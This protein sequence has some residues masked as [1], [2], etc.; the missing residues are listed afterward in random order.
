VP[1]SI[2][3]DQDELGNGPDGAVLLQAVQEQVCSL[4]KCMLQGFS[5]LAQALRAMPWRT[6]TCVPA[7]NEMIS[8]EAD[9]G[10]IETFKDLLVEEYRLRGQCP[11]SHLDD[12]LRMLRTAY[13][14][15]YGLFGRGCDGASAG[16][17][18]HG[19]ALGTGE[20]VDFLRAE[21][22]R[23]ADAFDAGL[24]DFRRF[25]ESPTDCAVQRST[26]VALI[27]VLARAMG[28]STDEAWRENLTTAHSFL[29]E[30]AVFDHPTMSRDSLEF[31]AAISPRG[32]SQHADLADTEL[33]RYVACG[34][35]LRRWQYL[36]GQIRQ[37]NFIFSVGEPYPR[38]LFWDGQR[39][40]ESVPN[41][42]RQL[43]GPCASDCGRGMAV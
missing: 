2:D 42:L 16:S 18:L 36:C 35:I 41:D 26:F 4:E 21:F 1:E 15:I 12:R 10:R 25:R 30:S 43:A 27:Y 13:S 37:M 8:N 3:L 28:C 39:W 11:P 32:L 40:T 9:Y 19:E 14:L 5:E 31:R 24:S 17:V 20:Q 22:D 23:L 29:L 6:A 7:E 33:Q 34:L 38:V